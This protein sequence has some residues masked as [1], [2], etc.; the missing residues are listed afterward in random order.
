MS[1]TMA[2]RAAE[3][4]EILQTVTDERSVAIMSYLTGNKWHVAKI[5]FYRLDANQLTV[6]LTPANKR[7]PI[8]IRIGQL[9]G[10]SLKY[11]YSKLIFN[12]K[13][14]GFAPPDDSTSGGKIELALPKRVEVIQKRSYFRVTVPY[15]LGIDATI[16][17]RGKTL[18]PSA[19]KNLTPGKSANYWQGNIIDIS[20][21]GA[22]ITIGLDQKPD[23]GKGKFIS[24]SFTPLPN[25]APMLLNAQIRNVLPTADG[26]NIC[27]GIQFTG[28]EASSEGH[29]TLHRLCEIVESYHQ[30]NEAGT[31]Q[32]RLQS[33]EL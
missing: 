7:Y 30:I 6:S 5:T 29:A 2:L 10:V 26:K 3:P 17:H 32:Q 24:F 28:L 23:F 11:G 16:W 20:A 4:R 9:V 21:G 31:K 22:Q 12:T 8:N 18:E 33:I 27:I 13:I 19:N 25:E 14:V 15:S 1:N